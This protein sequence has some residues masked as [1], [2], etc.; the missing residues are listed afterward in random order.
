MRH[1]RQSKGSRTGQDSASSGISLAEVSKGAL[2]FMQVSAIHVALPFLSAPSQN[3]HQLCAGLWTCWASGGKASVIG[4]QELDAH[5]TNWAQLLGDRFG[6]V[7]GK[8]LRDCEDVVLITWCS[9]VS[10][11]G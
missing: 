5:L 3:Y 1:E 2:Q 9:I 6:L 10:Q 4:V 11:L 8:F 7:T